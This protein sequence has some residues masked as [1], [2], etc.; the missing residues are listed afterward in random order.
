VEEVVEEND[1]LFESVKISS[2][3]HHSALLARISCRC[4]ALAA[5]AAAVTPQWVDAMA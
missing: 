1:E 4:S 3:L 2:F 5:L